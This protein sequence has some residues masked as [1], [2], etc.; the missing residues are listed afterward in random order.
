[1]NFQEFLQN[2]FHQKDILDNSKST[3]LAFLCGSFQFLKILPKL[4]NFE[5][6]HHNAHF[7]MLS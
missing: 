5:S 2:W 3:I 1:M 4:K 7:K 6:V